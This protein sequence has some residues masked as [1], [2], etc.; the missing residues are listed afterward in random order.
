MPGR[1]KLYYNPQSRAAVARWMLEE[2]GA[3]YEIVPVSFD[4]GD[5][6]TPEFLALNPM[7]KLPTM[8]LD[9]GTVVTEV[10][11]IIAWLADAF[12][13]AELAPKPGTGARGSYYR[14]LFFG[15]SCLEPALA[16]RSLQEGA[17]ELA[18]SR[19]GWGSYDDVV[20]TL[21]T[22]LS[23][24]PYLCGDRFSGA[25]LY[26]GA[27]LHFATTF[28]APRLADSKTIRDYVARV[29]AREAL[30]RSQAPV[31]A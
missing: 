3:D 8:V 12:P 20:D 6:R 19:V 30:E 11:A 21:E 15:G 9:D 26:I 28:K 5:N 24:R 31:A 18:K 17:A 2:V 27:M 4:A 25:D 14:W 1:L 10:P 7:G 16:V 29:T 23:A 13:Q 22:V